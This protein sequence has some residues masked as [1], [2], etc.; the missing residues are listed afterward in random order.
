[1]KGIAWHIW[2]F[3]VSV[4]FPI[5]LNAIFFFFSQQKACIFNQRLSELQGEE[6]HCLYN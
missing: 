2:K 3:R 4:H 1:M 6:I 5:K